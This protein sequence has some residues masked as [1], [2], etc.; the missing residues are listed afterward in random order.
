M[1]T[2]EYLEKNYDAAES[3]WEMTLGDFI[4]LM[5]LMK[6][7]DKSDLGHQMKLISLISTIPLEL[8]EEMDFARFVQLAEICTFGEIDL[9]QLVTSEDLGVEHRGPI[10]FEVEGTTFV[11]QPDYA[12]SKM[13]YI[14]KVEDFLRGKDL[15][16]N[17]HWVL[18]FCAFEEGKTDTFDLDSEMLNKKAELMCKAKMEDVFRPLFFFAQQKQNSLLF[19]KHFS[20][21]AQAA[22]AK[23]LTSKIAGGGTE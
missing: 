17:L 13:K 23:L 20:L 15:M 10:T 1:R 12:Y 8:L 5:E 19:T 2:I 18:A 14:A 11:F 22:Q 21:S 7:E 16:E 3:V 6:A 4:D 9:P